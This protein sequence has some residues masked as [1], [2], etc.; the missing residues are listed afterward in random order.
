VAAGRGRPSLEALS[1]GIVEGRRA[2]LG[3]AVTLVESENRGHREQA[4]TLLE[5]LLPR[6]GQA[7]RVGITGVP[8][9]GK[10][11]F[12]D[13]L[14]THLTG[15]GHRVAVLAVDPTSDRSGGSILG[16]KTRMARLA[17]DPAAFV[18]PSP[19][20]GAL[21]GVARKTRESIL[22]VEAAGYDVVLV[23]TV[24]VGQ[25]EVTVARMVDCFLVLMLPHA[26]DELQGIKRGILE[27]A[28]LLAVNKVDV[29]RTAAERARR[30]Y[31]S[32]MHLYRPRYPEWTPETCC[33]SGKTGEG[34]EELWERVLAHHGAL[35]ESGA[36]GRLRSEQAVGWMWHAVEA[37]L[38]SRLRRDSAVREEAARLEAGVRDGTTSPTAAAAA[39]LRAFGVDV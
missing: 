38:T 31:E 35:S 37:E 24:G 28:D 12:I 17:R 20:Q 30:Q 7:Y 36:L 3:R 19:S 33:V 22:L 27:L 13:A 11:T 34:I 5:G 39:I 26:G 1:E 6:T 16:D 10:S 4:Q 2:V 29:D 18:R 23:E 15:R 25:S 9:V 32:A 21:G 8:G 14:G